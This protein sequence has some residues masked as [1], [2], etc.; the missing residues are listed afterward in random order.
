MTDDAARR[1]PRLTLSD[2]AHVAEIVASLAVVVTLVFLVVEVRQNTEITRVTAYDRTVEGLNTWRL[3]VASDP[4]LAE[5]WQ[6]Y[7]SNSAAQ[8]PAADMRLQLLL[9]TLWAAYESAYYAWRYEILGSSEWTRFAF[10]ICLRYESDGTPW[11]RPSSGQPIRD[12]LT[13]EFVGYV[14]ATC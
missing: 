1:A 4:D 2:L 14:E 6:A 9:N 13:D 12:L 5:R 10:Q 3:T 8:D 7:M 11:S